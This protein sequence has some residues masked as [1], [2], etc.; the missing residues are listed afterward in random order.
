MQHLSNNLSEL[1]FIRHGF[2]TRDGGVSDGL[3]AS[4]NCGPGSNDAAE[5]VSE[6]RRRVRE[7]LNL[8]ALITLSQIHSHRVETVA[9]GDATQKESLAIDRV[10]AEKDVR[11][12]QADALVTDRPGI[13]LG[14]LTADCGPVLFADPSAS[15]IGAAHAGWRGALN[16]VLERTLEAMERLGAR[17]N[18]INAALGPTI[19]QPSYE[20]DTEFYER[21]YQADPDNARFFVPSTPIRYEPFPTHIEQTIRAYQFDLPGYICH[22]LLQSGLRQVES[23]DIDTY[24]NESRC[25][26]YRRATHRNEADYGRQISVIALQE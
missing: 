17:R 15:V 7:R 6:N 20:V 21:F 18:R 23:V 16:G 2:F 8:S 24:K 26:S 9:A 5:A 11:G 19:A 22:R 3:Y 13:G 4:L 25:F 10:L 14:I 12:P 1:A